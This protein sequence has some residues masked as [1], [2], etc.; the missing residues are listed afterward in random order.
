LI[1]LVFVGL[2]VDKVTGIY[3]RMN[4]H[5]AE[6]KKTTFE[7][8]K[9]LNWYN[10][11]L[12]L[13]ERTMR[14][15]QHIFDHKK[16]G[17]VREN[18]KVWLK[19][20]GELLP[21]LNMSLF[22]GFILRHPLLSHLPQ[23]TLTIICELCE[24]NFFPPTDLLVTAGK[25]PDRMIYLRF[26]TAELVPQSPVE[27]EKQY[28]KASCFRKPT[29]HALRSNTQT[30]FTVSQAGFAGLTEVEQICAGDILFSRELLLPCQERNTSTGVCKSFC[31][32]ISLEFAKF[33]SAMERHDPATLQVI[34]ISAAINEDSVDML[35][36][37]LASVGIRN[38][39]TRIAGEA[40]LH[41]CARQGANACTDFLIQRLGADLNAKDEAGSTAVEI[42]TLA[43]QKST[44]DLLVAHGAELPG[45]KHRVLSRGCTGA[46]P[47]HLKILMGT[48]P[49]STQEELESRLQKAGV[50]LSKWGI[51]GAKRLSDLFEEVRSGKCACVADSGQGGQMT[52]IA[53]V[54]RIKVHA[55]CGGQVKVL[56]ATETQTWFRHAGQ[57][58]RLPA[59][60]M[61]HGQLDNALEDLWFEKFGL[62]VPYVNDNFT[63]F[64]VE[65]F[66]EEKTS[67]SYPGL[68]CVYIVHEVPYW[69][70]EPL[71]DC[72][73]LGLP[74]G[75]IVERSAP[76]WPD[77]HMETCCYVWIAQDKDEAAQAAKTRANS[78]DIGDRSRRN[79]R[80]HSEPTLNLATIISMHS[81]VKFSHHASLPV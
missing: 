31:E 34:R 41:R 19:S 81:D 79:S 49:D 29:L 11:P 33:N 70:C 65:I 62:C 45:N 35:S 5:Q 2:I 30:Q 64:G 78:E 51:D 50:D 40:P 71:A 23:D 21:D 26:G 67:A 56:H 12:E 37:A 63:Q 14:Y 8:S 18:L 55:A 66:A 15:V 44:V 9:F 80:L 17:D 7:I 24:V 61:A 22:G 20:S 10:V 60:L 57:V 74:E 54:L 68:R 27:L 6:V 52:R 48:V 39:N 58:L 47:D 42:A 77:G 46:T 32:T 43:R 38:V 3:A 73:A 53:C 69:A 76:R 25:L 4:E 16:L 13:Q 59:Q 28:S 1:A 36:W 75:S 72:E